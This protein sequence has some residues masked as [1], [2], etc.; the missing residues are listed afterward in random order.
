VVLNDNVILDRCVIDITH[1]VYTVLNGFILKKL[2]KTNVLTEVCRFERLFLL[3]MGG[4][5]DRL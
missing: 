1:S 3:K 4:Y 2:Y 5:D